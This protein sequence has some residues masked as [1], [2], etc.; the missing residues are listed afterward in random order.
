PAISSTTIK[1]RNQ[2]SLLRLLKPTYAWPPRIAPT[3]RPNQSDRKPASRHPHHGSPPPPGGRRIVDRP[4]WPSSGLRT[5]AIHVQHRHLHHQFILMSILLENGA[6]KHSS[7]A[8]FPLR[9]VIKK[10]ARGTTSTNG[11]PKDQLRPTHD[12]ESPSVVLAAFG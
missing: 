12:L 5:P 4:R 11:D 7:D 3:S 10:E 9:Y 6:N 2:R 1:A 8:W